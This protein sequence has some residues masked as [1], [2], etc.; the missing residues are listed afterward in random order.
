[1]TIR[2]S[3]E[4]T[5]YLLD[6]SFTPPR[7]VGIRQA[8]G[9]EHYYSFSTTQ[10]QSNYPASALTANKG[11]LFG[12]TLANGTDATNDFDVAA[13]VCS[14][15][16]GV[17]LLV[18]GAM[19]KQLDAAWAAGTN[20]GGRLSAAAIAN[21][22]YFVFAILKD[23]DGSVDYGFDVSPTAPTMPSGYTY[24]RRIGIAWRVGGTLLAFKQ[25]GDYFELSVQKTL[26]AATNPGTSRVQAPANGPTGL[27]LPCRASAA[28]SDATPD[29]ATAVLITA[30]D[31]PDTAPGGGN[32][33]L[34]TQAT[35]AT[36]PTRVSGQYD[37]VLDVA[38]QFYYRFSQSTPDHRID[39]LMDGWI[40]TRGQ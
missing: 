13:G 35:G 27:V 18:G 26:V 25:R 10:P 2:A 24:F 7:V 30:S 36:A 22:T 6:D 14:D 3:A 32:F 39:I 29:A 17:R 31:Q 34:Y 33:S 12:M 28:L 9:T 19:T 8:D 4:G 15:S 16:T 21:T 5:A 38:G 37:I 20:A 1:M 23:S 40:D 11:Q